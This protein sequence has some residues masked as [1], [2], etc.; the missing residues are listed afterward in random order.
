[1]DE[2]AP[3]RAKKPKRSTPITRLTAEERAKQFSEDFYADGGVLFC[4][5][6]EHSLD[7]VRIDTVKDHIKSKKHGAK[8]E[9]KKQS[10]PAGPLSVRQTTLGTMAKSKDMRESFVLD[11]LKMCTTADIP[12]EKTEMIRPFL[13]KHCKQAGALPQV[14]TLRTTYVPRLFEAHFSALQDLLH[15]EPVSITADETTDVRDHSILNVI[16]GVQGKPFLIGVVKMEACNHSTFSQ[17]I[18][19]S[20][21]EAGIAFENVTSIVSDSAAYCKKAYRDVLSAVYP[22]SVHVLCL[23]HIVNLA[24]EVFHHHSDFSHTS[25]L[26]TMIKSSLFKKPGRKSRLLKY[27]SDFISSAEV[28]LPPVPVSSRWNSWFEAA[29]YHATRIHLYEGF[30]KAERGQGMAVERIIELVTHKE[31]YPEISLQLYFVKENCQRLMAVLTSLEANETPL[32]CTV[33]NLLEDL[34][35]YLRAGASKDRFGPET[36]RLLDKFAADQKRKYV[37]SFQTIFKLSLC[38]LDGHLD[39]HPAHLHYKAVRVF[40]P[41]QLPTLGNN[42][43]EYGAIKALQD[44]LPELLEEWLIYTQYRDELPSPFSIPAFWKGMK[45]RFPHLSTIGAAAIWMPV[46]SVDVERSFSQYKHILNDRRESLTEQN[47]KRLVMLYFNGDIE[48]RFC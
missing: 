43:E 38:K 8:K 33:Y 44:P 6:C 45:D 32:A 22:N 18:I 11:Y 7:F 4:R 40:D 41:R 24:A 20:V 34:R 48:G 15:N 19:Q 37:K 46:A 35:S 31:I 9:S 14:A 29:I 28:K 10:G 47:T 27:M 23:A 5:F 36:D 2:L 39:K 42:I 12:L 26:I 3:P 13:Q 25:D 30:F 17:A 21:S 1:M 16:A